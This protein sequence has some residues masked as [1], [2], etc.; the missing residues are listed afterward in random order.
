MTHNEGLKANEI[1]FKNLIG[2]LNEGGVWVFP[3]IMQSYIKKNGK[4]VAGNR[5]AYETIRSI[6][7]KNI[8]NLFDIDL[9]LCCPQLN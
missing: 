7:P 6:T 9:S 4:L 3:N 8:H 2:S 1:F 5:F